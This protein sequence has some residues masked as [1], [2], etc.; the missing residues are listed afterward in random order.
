MDVE[1]Y[2]EVGKV[3]YEALM[4]AK[5]LVKLGAKLL[6]VAEAT[7]AFIK[8]RGFEMAFPTNLSVGH[9][10]AHYTPSFGDSKVF[11]AE[12]VVKVDVGARRGDMLG[13]CAITVD[14]SGK[15]GKLAEA[16]ENALNAAISMV[17]AGRKLG[18]MGRE[19][20]RIANA[21]GFN[22]IR[23][24]G[25]HGIDA[26]ELHANIF[27]PNYDNGDQTELEEGKVIAIETFITTGKGLVKDGDIVQIF[28]KTAD[29]TPRLNITRDVLSYISSNYS[30]YPFAIRWL[31]SK[32]NSEFMVKTALNELYSINALE[33]FPVLVEESKGIVAQTEKTMIVEKDSAMVLTE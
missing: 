8:G 32:Y 20:E 9:E 19:V 3:S 27:I 14:L 10:A 26:G 25:G 30:T 29:S 22:P 4:H 5:A 13:D 1:A 24:L 23:N 11:T 31:I 33:S 12:D 7:E 6:D 17:K 28:Q 2:A 16:S 15:Y 18:E 21:N